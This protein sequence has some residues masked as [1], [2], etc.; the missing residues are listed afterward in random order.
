MESQKTKKKSIAALIWRWVK[1]GFIGIL[2]LWVALAIAVQIPAV[3]EFVIGEI[4]KQISDKTETTVKAKG[5]RLRLFNSLSLRGLYIEDHNGDT[6]L[7]A[8]DFQIEFENPIYSYIQGRDFL[9]KGV[10]LKSGGFYQ[11]KRK[12]ETQTN[13]EVFLDAFGSSADRS[14]ESPPD[15]SNLGFAI[16]L[17]E[18]L[19]KDAEFVRQDS[20]AGS[21]QRFAIKDGLIVPDRID[22]ENR[23]ISIKD[24]I[25]ESPRIELYSFPGTMMEFEEN[26]RI[27][28]LDPKGVG[29]DPWLVQC[30]QF[31]LSDGFF[32]RYNLIENPNPSSVVGALDWQRLDLDQIFIDVSDFNLYNWNFDGC[33]H[34]LSVQSSSGLSIN[35][36][37]A[38]Y[39]HVDTNIVDLEGVQLETTGSEIIADVELKYDAFTDFREFKDEVNIHFLSQKTDIQIS[40][41][42]QFAP[43]LRKVRFFRESANQLIKLS[44]DVRGPVNKLTGKN[45][46]LDLG[47]QTSLEGNFRSENLAEGDQAY[48]F[49]KIDQSNSNMDDLYRI[50]PGF[51]PP[52]NFKNLGRLNFKGKFEG[53]FKDFVAEGILNSDIG[54]AEMKMKM[55]V[56]KGAD[57][58]VYSGGL[59]LINFDLG[60][61][62]DNADLGRINLYADVTEGNGLSLEHLSTRILATVEGF[63]YKGYTFN[64][65]N[66]NGTFEGPLF[67]GKFDILDEF[68]N[69][70]FRG[71]VNLAEELPQ[72]DIDADI[73]QIHLGKLQLTEENIQVSGGVKA[74]IDNYKINELAARFVLDDF[75]LI[76]DDTIR[77]EIDSLEA[78]SRKISSTNR[79]LHIHAPQLDLTLEGRYKPTHL[80]ASFQHK[81]SKDYPEYAEFLKVSYDSSNVSPQ[82]FYL[83]LDIHDTE[84]WLQLLSPDIDSLYGSTVNLFWDD[85]KDSIYFESYVPHFKKGNQDLH[86]AYVF[87]DSRSGLSNIVTYVDSASFGE[88]FGIEAFTGQF[89][90]NADTLFWSFNILDKERAEDRFNFEG[91][92]FIIDTNFAFKLLNRNLEFFFD[93]WDVNP[94]NLAQINREFIRLDNFDMNF[95]DRKISL[96]SINDEGLSLGIENVELSLLNDILVTDKFSFDGL[97]SAS[98]YKPNI[99]EVSALNGSLQIDSLNINGDD[100]GNLSASASSDLEDSPLRVDGELEHP[101][102]GL[103][104]NGFLFADATGVT[105]DFYALDLQLDR[106][107][108]HILTYFVREGISDVEGHLTGKF[109]MSGAVDKPILK[110]E[111]LVQKG[112]VT[113]DF[114]G[115]RLFIENQLVQLDENLID[116][117]KAEIID[118][119]GNAATLTGGLK[120]DYFRDLSLDLSIQ[121]DKFLLLNT[122][123]DDG[124]MYYGHCMGSAQVDM[125]GPLGSPKIDIV[126]E[127]KEDTRFFLRTDYIDDDVTAGYFRYEDFSDTST[128]EKNTLEAPTGIDFSLNL[129]ANDRAEVEIIIDKKTG[130]I[131]RGRGRGNIQFNLNRAGDISMFGDY[132]ITRGQY[133]FTSQVIIQKPFAVAPGST[134]SWTGD[135]L[136]ALINI[137]AQYSVFTS[138]YFLVQEMVTQPDQIREFQN[139]TEVILNVELTGMLYSPQL[140]FTIDF[141]NLTGPARS[142]VENK[143]TLLESDPNE[144]YKQAGALIVLNT[145]VPSAVGG[146]RDIGVAAGVN[147]LS[148]FVSSQ[149]SNVLSNIL[150]SAVEDVEFI[151]D[152]DLDLN[153]N[154]G[155]DDVVRGE[156]LE[157]NSG[158]FRVSTT[159]RL[160]DRV[161]LD[162]GTNYFVGNTNSVGAT[163]AGTFFT[164]NFALQYA[165]TE[166]RQLMLRVYSLSDQVLEGRRFRSGVGIRHQKEFDSFDSFYSGLEKAAQKLRIMPKDP[167]SDQDTSE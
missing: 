144:M 121:S 19:L 130:D 138:P 124:I 142:I 12:G 128:T 67:N 140:A 57:D 79:E 95:Q 32:R 62:S 104:F 157:I 63:T 122:T 74:R 127:N 108:M 17:N 110:G 25:L 91:K 35:N 65:F 37:S 8:N 41:L 106:L 149:F 16:D 112:A 126:A 165:L 49:A 73:L 99:Y 46:S 31:S 118:I 4:T 66:M 158:Q 101:D 132:E 6:L 55:D 30:R 153:Y 5:F 119:Y 48:L 85:E 13:V 120:H 163:D 36:F 143:L 58:A 131:I 40:D 113:I 60:A 161:E 51:S 107:P 98:V 133:L 88:R 145:F 80:W 92:S 162:V 76:Q 72:I 84:N 86:D 2:L 7:F 11:R 94:Q 61:L 115:I 156:G 22:F 50:I 136:D 90:L 3:Q 21:Y 166:D 26:T 56:K 117:S 18:V 148:E 159:A 33:L 111:G 59:N 44:G 38:N 45:F 15:S 89:D 28:T 83:D 71:K 87:L 150:R 97:F 102:H 93:S 54:K 52:E 155:T 135:P 47:Q 29:P 43:G 154:V 123:E 1:R 137:K 114:L 147:T 151:D 10:Q 14:G 70:S 129:T 77:H 109:K 34:Q 152:I 139:N 116:A 24:V 75:T 103:K 9:V 20:V 78:Y 125:S 167:S 53:A 23:E 146:G 105:S 42:I 81:F 82:K 39:V 96:K 141:P 69:F 100:Y 68:L 160:F 64:N 27:N 134:I 164:G